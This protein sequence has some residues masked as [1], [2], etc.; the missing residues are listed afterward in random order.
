MQVNDAHACLGQCAGCVLHPD[1]RR[2][3]TPSMSAPMLD[4]AVSRMHDYAAGLAPLKRVNVIFGVADHVL[5]GADYLVDLHRRGSAVV[6]AGRPSDTARSAVFFT[7]SLVGR[8]DRVVAMLRE[9]R[10]RMQGPIPFVPLVVLDGRFMGEMKFGPIW[11]DMVGEARRLF[12]R[13]DLATNLSAD[14][15]AAMTPA[16]LVAFADANGFDEISVNW[17]P[18]L[19]NAPR[20]LVDMPGLERWLLEFDDLLE[21]RPNIQ[22]TYRPVIARIMSAFDARQ[23]GTRPTMMDTVDEIVP[24][25]LR[26]QFEIDHDGSL[27]PKFEAVGDVAHAPRHGLKAIGNVR[28]A[29]ISD[30]VEAA[31]PRVKAR[32]ASIHARGACAR[33]GHAAACAGSGFHVATSVMRA[34]GLADEEEGCPHV[35]AAL[36]SRI[37]ER[38]A[39]GDATVA[40]FA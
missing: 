29:S 12:G 19:A 2:V 16:Q 34:A 21:A 37:A 14:A 11:R 36:I 3:S 23:D 15:V 28:L 32:I 8:Q 30:L 25:T 5:F 26:K 38:R 20:T 18:T 31:I 4:L 17:S 6:L 33:C 39:R 27:L 7:T 1:E 40:A 13:V 35:A 9:V 10:S 22:T 24:E